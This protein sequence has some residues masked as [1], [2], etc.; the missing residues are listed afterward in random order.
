MK[1]QESKRLLVGTVVMWDGDENDLGTVRQV[2]STAVFID[3]ANG[4]RG[5]IDHRD[6][7]KVD[8]R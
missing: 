5:W 8:I 1:Y 3:W 7:R 4:Q 6:M 2:T